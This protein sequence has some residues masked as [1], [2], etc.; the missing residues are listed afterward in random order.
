MAAGHVAEPRSRPC[1]CVRGSGPRATKTT[2]GRGEVGRGSRPAERSVHRPGDGPAT[3]ATWSPVRRVVAGGTPAWRLTFDVLCQRPWE[4]GRVGHAEPRPV[5]DTAC[6]AS[7]RP[8]PWV[9]LC[10]AS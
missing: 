6:P 4:P 3:W 9:C 8:G 1:H 7:C 2:G 10:P 5:V